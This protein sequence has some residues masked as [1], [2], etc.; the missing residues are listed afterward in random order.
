MAAIETSAQPDYALTI[1]TPS[2]AARL[3]RTPSEWFWR[4]PVVEIGPAF[5]T[6]RRRRATAK[7]MSALLGV[8][9]CQPAALAALVVLGFRAWVAFTVGKA[10]IGTI[11]GALGAALAAA[12]LAKAAALLLSRGF[13]ALELLRLLARARASMQTPVPRR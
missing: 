8:C 4:H 3:L 5:G 1:A 6:E 11:A 10:G 9:G 7:Q 12:L 2:D 13:F